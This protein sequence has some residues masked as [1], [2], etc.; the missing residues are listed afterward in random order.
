MRKRLISLALALLLILFLA[1]C[2]EET[3]QADS[4]KPQIV[5]TLFPY[6]DIARAIAGDRA[7]VTLLI[8]AGRESH[9]YEPTPLD[10]IRISEADLFLYNGGTDE[11]WATEVLS[12]M[13]HGR[14][15]AM[16]EQVEKREEELA[17][18]MQAE[19]GHDHDHE[20][21]DE[22]DHDHEDEDGHALEIEYDEHIWT[23]PANAMTIASVIARALTELDGAG[24]AYYAAN[25]ERYLAELSSLDEAFR[26]TVAE[27]NRSLIVLGDR[28]PLLYF[29]EE[30][31]LSYRAAFLGCSTET[32]PSAA[33]MAYLIDRVREEQIP[34]VYYLENSSG[35]VAEAIA[36]ATG[37]EPMVFYSCQTVSPEDFR[38]GETYLSLMWR[39]VEALQK[40]LA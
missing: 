7:E 36:E 2:G 30:Y 13:D 27:G 9:S 34:V 1:A 10:I 22:H 6:Y 31:G 16:M 37:A 29:C 35:R 23:S 3:P 28:F 40:G 21:G 11:T 8:S 38:A 15:I 20:D 5:A 32:E 12:T 18:G 24:A 17:E 39:N 14:A 4:G 33:T 25:L 19:R 26:E